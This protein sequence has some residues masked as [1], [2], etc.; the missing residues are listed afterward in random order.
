MSLIVAVTGGIGSGKSTAARM[1]QECGADVVD[2]DAIA[3]EL[4]RPGQRALAEIVAQF[5]PEH[6]A[7]DGS[8]DRGKLGGRVFSDPEARRRLERILHPAI[9]REVQMRVHAG[10]APY[11]LVLIPL[12]VE[13]GGYRDLGQ[14]VLVIDCDERLQVRRAMQRG[15]LKEEQVQAIM[16]AQA[17]RSQRLAQADD[18]IHNDGSLEELR[19]QVEVLD[20]RYR[21]LASAAR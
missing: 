15:G 17:T 21:A 12:L 6:L 20:A 4:T 14:R 3:H 1:F 19:R 13:T 8:L 2:T 7:T 11:A 5:G 9:E 10:A 18:I 16:R